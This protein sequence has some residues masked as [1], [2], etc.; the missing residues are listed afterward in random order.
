MFNITVDILFAMDI[1]IIFLTAYY[2]DDFE[3]IDDPKDIAKSYIK[4][5]FFLDTFAIFPFDAL[6]PE[7]D[8]T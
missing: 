7:V 4:G 8:Q 2:N 1:I 6:Q 3:L 5:W